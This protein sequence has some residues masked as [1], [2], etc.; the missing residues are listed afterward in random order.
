MIIKPNYTPLPTPSFQPAAW[1]CILELSA[2][3]VTIPSFTRGLWK[4]L[5][6]LGIAEK[7]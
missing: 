3:S 1:S 4:T 7:I 2:C 6:P 5:Q